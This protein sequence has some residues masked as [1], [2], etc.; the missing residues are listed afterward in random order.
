MHGES[1]TR[2]VLRVLVASAIMVAVTAPI[3]MRLYRR[4]R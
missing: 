3:A 4:D 1:A 2:D